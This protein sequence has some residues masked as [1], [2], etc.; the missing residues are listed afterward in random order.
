ALRALCDR[1][2]SGGGGPARVTA[3]GDGAAA[4]LRELGLAGR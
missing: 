2:W 4:A 3:Q 1:H